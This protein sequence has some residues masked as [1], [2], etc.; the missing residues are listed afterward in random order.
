MAPRAL[1]SPRSENL[2]LSREAGSYHS[3]REV[4]WPL[5]FELDPND[6]WDKVVDS[7]TGK[8]IF[9]PT[10]RRR[11]CTYVEPSSRPESGYTLY[12]FV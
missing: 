8:E 7:S 12:G 11:E 9:V 10:A 3:L 2:S 5:L 4:P 1:T 6:E